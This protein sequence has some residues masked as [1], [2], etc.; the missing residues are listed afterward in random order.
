MV[1]RDGQA[2]SAPSQRFLRKHCPGFILVEIWGAVFKA[3]AELS[4]GTYGAA[5]LRSRAVTRDARV[6][7]WP[8]ADL[9]SQVP[10]PDC[11][12]PFKDTGLQ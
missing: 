6:R 8:L 11:N 12:R 1:T 2:S 3:K 9:T 5:I 4:A 7:T 10:P